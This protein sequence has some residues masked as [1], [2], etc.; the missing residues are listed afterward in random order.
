M[1]KKVKTEDA[2]MYNTEVIYSSVMYLLNAK[3]IDLKVLFK[4]ELSPVSLSLFGETGDS[5]LAKQK[6]DL[7]KTLKEEVSLRTCL[8]ENAAVL[9]GCALYWSVHWPKAGNFSNLVNVFK[10]Y[11]M[12]FPNKSNVFLIFDWYHDYS[13]KGFTHQD[14]VGSTRCLH[15]LSLSTPLPSK[16]VTLHS[17]DT[18]K[19]LIKLL[20]EGLLKVYTNAPC[21]RK[22]VIISQNEC[23]VQVHLGIKTLCHGMST[24][25]EEANV[26]IP[27]EVIIVIEEGATCV[28]VISDDTDVYFTAVFL[29]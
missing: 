12:K 28:K 17:T 5:K 10:D 21:E 24:R 15:N 29:Y 27:P 6:A 25:H 13:I 1:K 16:E 14:H 8:S 18:K 23:P 3:Q 2:V 7:K 4:Y 26:I 22:L 19:Q 11:I 20:A 9:D